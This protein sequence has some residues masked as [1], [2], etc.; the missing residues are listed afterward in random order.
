MLEPVVYDR[1][2][3]ISE[4]LMLLREGGEDARVLAG[5]QS[6]V[7]MMN[8]GL[9]A[10]SMLVDISRVAELKTVAVE[11]EYL[12]I[13]SALTQT[14]MMHDELVREH[15]PL[16]PK[17]ALNIGSVRIRN[18]GTLGG[19]IAHGDSAAELPLSAHV[20]EAEYRVDNP[21]GHEWRR[22]ADFSQG[23]YQTDLAPG[24]LLTQ[25]RIPLRPGWGWGFSEYARRVGDFALAAGAAGV[26]L[27]GDRIERAHIAATG[28]TEVPLRLTAVEKALQGA[29]VDDVR[30]AVTGFAADLDVSDAPYV[31]AFERRRITESVVLRAI[32]RA[33]RDAHDAQ[34]GS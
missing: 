23:H 29:R 11:G 5:G 9:A 22:A 16:L 18:R 26:S 31:S 17:A 24:E 34:G 27:S 14:D 13:G 7:P 3:S 4:A 6:L 21:E 30:G 8:L 1:A 2:R 32:T 15:A 33:C 28:C 25:I 10:P 19:S 12:V 20:L